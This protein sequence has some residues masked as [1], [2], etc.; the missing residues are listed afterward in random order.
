MFPLKEKYKMI[1]Q[2]VIGFGLLFLAINFMK[3]S[4]E[5]LQTNFDLAKYKDVS[6]W[7]FGLIGMVTTAI[8]H[9]SGA[10]GI[11]TLAALDGGII[12]FPASV[13]INM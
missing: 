3:E 6:L 2:F 11:M 5:A 13:A 4:V 7:A 8:L 1:A 12:S 9:S 10:L